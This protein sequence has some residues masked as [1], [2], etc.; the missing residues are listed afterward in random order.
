MYDTALEST[1][2][3]YIMYL[4]KTTQYIPERT[5]VKQANNILV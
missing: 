1:E 4:W 3:L 5:T 2:I